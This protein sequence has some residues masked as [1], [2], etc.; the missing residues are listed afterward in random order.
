M[1]EKQMKGMTPTK[2]RIIL[3]ITIVLLL[4]I[5]AFGF[6]FFRGQL[7]A[8]AEEVNK[9][10]REAT[11]STNDI[12]TLEKLKK[13]LQD[14]KVA[15]TRANNIVADSKSYQYQDQ[16]INDLSVYAKVAGVVVSGYSFISDIPAA[17]S[18]STSTSAATS[19]TQAPAPAPSGLKSTKVA[20]T[21]KNPV[22]YRATMRFIHAIEL[23]LT[24]MQLA[25]ISLTGSADNKNQV[26]AN[27]L[28]IEVYI[29]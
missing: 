25:G 20:I 14:D 24:K 23:N 16:I 6:M 7:V 27:P 26:S 18:A 19:D 1:I 4:V 10:A 2:L 3:C 5:A 13:E 15:V 21:L 12:A 29:R 28:T 9:S 11:I 22:D 17:D 8:Y